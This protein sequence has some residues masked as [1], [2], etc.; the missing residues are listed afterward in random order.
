M[1]S[2]I[3]RQFIFPVV[4]VNGGPGLQIRSAGITDQQSAL[5]ITELTGAVTNTQKM[6]DEKDPITVIMPK[7]YPA[8]KLESAG[9]FKTRPSCCIVDC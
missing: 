5:L 8:Q 3:I 9:N 1:E 2:P 7:W 6:K 4:T